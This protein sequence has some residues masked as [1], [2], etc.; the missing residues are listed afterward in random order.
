MVT[1]V[2]I[3]NNAYTLIMRLMDLEKDAIA[4]YD[5]LLERLDQ[6]ENKAEVGR[7]RQDHETHFEL[8]KEFAATHEVPPPEKPDEK[9][10][11]AKW[12]LKVADLVGDDR[13]LLKA[14]R[15][16]EGDLVDAYEATLANRVLP[17]EMKPAVER[18]LSDEHRHKAWMDEAG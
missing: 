15:G 3:Q 9:G 14:M 6:A 1:S 5:E 8:L 17:D 18:A 16:L 13:A 10:L 11:L 4:A 7:F 12:R 2:G